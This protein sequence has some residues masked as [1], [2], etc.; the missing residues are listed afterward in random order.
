MYVRF[1]SWL[2]GLASFD[3][4][5]FRL[6]ASEAVCLD[7]QARALLEHTQEVLAGP[8]AVAAAPAVGTSVGMF[9]GCMYTGG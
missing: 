5:A 6:S 7:P 2:S 4:P 1:G 3:A 9:V 8:A